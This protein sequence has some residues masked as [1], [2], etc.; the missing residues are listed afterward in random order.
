[1]LSATIKLYKHKTLGNGNHPI[2]LQLIANRK[3]RKISLGFDASEKEWNSSTCRFRRSVPN[4]E[5][6]NMALMRYEL[7]AQKLIDE[8][9]LSG[10]PLSIVEFKRKFN[11]KQTSSTDFIEFAEELMAEMRQ[12]GKIGNMQ[13][14][15]NITNSVKKFADKKLNFEDI[16]VTFLHKWEVWLLGDKWD[17][18]GVAPSTANQYMRTISAIFNKAI[19]RD[20]IAH[21]LYPF[22]NQ[23]NPKGYS[24]AHLKSQPNHR[25]LSEEE[26]EKFKSFDKTKYSDLANAHN[27]FMFMYYCRGINWTDFCHLKP[28][29]I[30]DGRIIYTRQKTGK[31]FSVKISDALQEII[32]QYKGGSYLFPILSNFHKSPTQKANRIKK[33]I[34]QINRDLKEIAVRIGIEPDISTYTARHTYAMSL[35]RAGIR[36]GLISDAMG[37][38]DSKVTRHYLSSFEDEKIDETEIVL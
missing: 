15:K 25:A 5:Q 37:H 4:Y 19:S 28:G 13:V 12:S 10:K 38:A 2:I 21:E 26:L 36:L 17:R 22:R 32:D 3:V 24:Y 6:K 33:C 7:L 14:Y 11:G 29:N 18:K 20:L 1:M 35:K 23:F 27:Y 34:R 9:I 30:R 16:D 31:L 8:A